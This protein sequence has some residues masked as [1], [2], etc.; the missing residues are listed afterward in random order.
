MIIRTLLRRLPLLS[1]ALLLTSVPSWAVVSPIVI[2][3]VES[4]G[5]T[6]GDWFELYNAGPSPADLSGWKMLDNDNAHTAYVFPAQSVVPAGGYLVVEEAQFVFGLGGA[7]SVR[8]FDSLNNPILDYSW[9]A[10]ATTTYGRCPN[11]TGA[12]T[13]TTS[14]TKGAANDCSTP[15]K[16][17]EVESSNGVPGDWVELYNPSASPVSV[18]GFTFKD[19]DDTHTAYTIPAGTLIAAGGYLVLD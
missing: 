18:A 19:N 11:G 13:T 1:L 8:L 4:N 3:E 14:S 7:D 17:N 10:H 12:L 2:N 15:I 9:A 5:G 6:P 16:I